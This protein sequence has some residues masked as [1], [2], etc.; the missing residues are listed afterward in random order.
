MSRHSVSVQVPLAEPPL[1]SAF[2]VFSLFLDRREVANVKE[3]KV[4]FKLLNSI[5][6]QWRKF[7]AM[8]FYGVARKIDLSRHFGERDYIHWTCN[9]MKA[10]IRILTNCILEQATKKPCC[11]RVVSWWPFRFSCQLCN[12]MIITFNSLYLYLTFPCVILD[13]PTSNLVILFTTL[14]LNFVSALRFTSHKTTARRKYKVT[15]SSNAQCYLSFRLHFFIL[16]SKDEIPLIHNRQINLKQEGFERVNPL[17]QEEK[18][19]L[20]FLNCRGKVL[21]F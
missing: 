16:L 15:K 21:L 7:L 1:L 12:L 19:S 11:P 18:I 14:T 5:G 8:N 10:L 17:S 9:H 6:T 2:H 20:V 4:F 13:R 3:N